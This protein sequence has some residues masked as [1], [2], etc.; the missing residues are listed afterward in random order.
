MVIGIL[1]KLLLWIAIVLGGLAGL[2]LCALRFLSPGRARAILNADGKPVPGSVSTIE[3][4]VLGGVEQ[5]VI[6]RGR[7]ATA[8]VM[9]F[10]HGGPGTPEYTLVQARNP[11][12]E[13]EFVMAWWEQRGA[14]LSYEA[15]RS[16]P[17]A[18]N[19]ARIVADTAELAEHLAA[20][21]GRERILLMGHSWGTLVGL[22]AVMAHPRLFA[23]YIGIGN[24]A[25]P[26][27]AERLSLDWSRARARELGWRRAIAAL[28]ALKLPPADG[29]T[30]QWMGYLR[31]QR[32]WLDRL[33]GGLTH[34]PL[35]PW[36]LMKPFF[37]APEYTLNDKRNYARGLLF[38]LESLWREVIGT[39]LCRDIGRLEIPVCFVQGAWDHQTPAG[40][41][42]ELFDGLEAPYKGFHLFEHSAHSPLIEEPEKF[43]E[44]VRAFRDRARA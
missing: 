43:N 42:R 29:D 33:G 7:D 19:L 18:M 36:G 34:E 5:T 31:A 32:R 10:L 15:G 6:I 24:L 21:F 9:L 35:G 25:R 28:D 27:A 30:A 1:L 38:S 12:L 37:T 8:P 16:D 20:R 23:G 26:Y 17:A 40:L 22:R 44:I 41:A 2:A 39:D 11:Q 3:R 13:R 4:I 14:G